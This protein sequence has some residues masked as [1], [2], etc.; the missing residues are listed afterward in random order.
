MD[1]LV[2]QLNV[3]LKGLRNIKEKFS[4]ILLIWSIG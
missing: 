1:T 2:A 3:S 4:G